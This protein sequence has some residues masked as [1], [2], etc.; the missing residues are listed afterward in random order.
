MLRFFLIF[1]LCAVVAQGADEDLLEGFEDDGFGDGVAVA[2]PQGDSFTLQSYGF[3]GKLTQEIAYAYHN[4]PPHDK[5]NSLRSTLFLEYNHELFDGWKIKLNG[6]AFYDWSYLAK[7]REKFSKEDKDALESQIEL[8]DAYIQGSLTQNLDL[9]LGRQVV[10]WGKSD[11]IRVVDIL[12]PLD[13]RRPG[14]VD[15]EDLRLPVTMAKF[16]YYIDK[17]HI[18]PIAILEQRKDKLPPFKGDF[19]PYPLPIPSIHKPKKLSFALNVGGEFEGYDVDFYY[20][21]TY[22]NFEFYPKQSIDITKKVNMLGA[23]AN[24]VTGSLLV[25]GEVAYFHNYRYAQD[26]TKYKRLDMLVGVEYN[27]ISETTLSVDLADKRFIDTL[28][29]N[30]ERDN[31]QGAFR[32]TSDFMHQTLHANYLISVFGKRFDAGGYQRLWVDY[33][34]SD[35][36]KT[37]VGLVDYLGGNLFFDAISDNDMVFAQCSYS[38]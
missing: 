37:T 21:N 6:N 17:W 20:A 14:M 33:D 19:N 12:N 35:S 38:F 31:L 8:F 30:A 2:Q 24:V 23:A 10:V 4:Q 1:V 25:K 18:T 13:N 34:V 16:D 26:S 15:I 27:G 28:P 9:K 36:I 5:V 11:T 7:G 32:I 29:Q 22:Q 3:E